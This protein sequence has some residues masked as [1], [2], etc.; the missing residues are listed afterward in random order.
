MT[1]PTLTEKVAE[2]I[3]RYNML[4]PGSRLGVAVSGGGDSVV[5]LHVL[6]R[7]S[8]R[9][10]V[11]LVVLH[12]N[13]LLRGSESDADQRFVS[14]LAAAL[15]LPFFS[16]RVPLST[17]NVEEQAR[18]AR[19]AFFRETRSRESLAAVALAH[20][21]SDQAETVL[22]RFLRGS[23]TAGLAGMPFVSS[24]HL[25]RPL[26]SID[27]AEI[28]AWGAEEGLA[29][30]EDSSNQSREFRRNLVR[31]EI[32]PILKREFNPNLESVLA[33]MADVAQAENAYW[34]EEISRLWGR[35][36]GRTRFGAAL[37]VRAFRD[38]PLALGRRLIRRAIAEVK[39][40]LRSI[41]LSHIEAV[42]KLFVSP[43]GHER[44]MIPGVDA[45]RSFGTLLLA[46]PGDLSAPRNYCFEIKPGEE[47]MLPFGAGLVCLNLLKGAA[48]NCASFKEVGPLAAESGDLDAMLLGTAPLMVR[49]WE[50]GD[51]LELNS[52]CVIK[53]KFLF[54]DSKVPLW[55]R[56]HWPVLVSESRVVWTR[57]FGC[58]FRFKPAS[59]DRP[60]FRIT[61]QP[62][63]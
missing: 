34:D 19:R 42:I 17:G 57:Q 53:L 14:D 49:N 61:Y 21:R 62:I 63:H 43:H 8:L 23:G 33:G 11:Q 38:L 12:C 39:G 20:T 51:A 15:A 26:L 41:D 35:V 30:R 1:L 13:H 32:L 28:R 22:L 50:P 29:W 47:T 48:L 54:Q 9:F 55:E 18:E 52:D 31:L 27:Q 45:L 56:R 59:D 10:A 58:S 37:D 24:D 6:H 44:V 25:I 4:S 46:V 5:L 60:R 7:I 40:D 16:S 2:I 3:T 36:A